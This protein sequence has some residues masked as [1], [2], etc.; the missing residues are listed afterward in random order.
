MDIII[1]LVFFDFDFSK[2][3]KKGITENNEIFSW[4]NNRFGELGIGLQRKFFFDNL[5]F[6]KGH[7]YSL[8]DS[9]KNIP[10]KIVSFENQQITSLSCGKSI[11]SCIN[12][13]K[14]K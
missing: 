2:I 13:T 10:Q 7:K 9:F 11:S 8:L 14:R 4:G 12:G 1:Q 5:S 6:S 3:L